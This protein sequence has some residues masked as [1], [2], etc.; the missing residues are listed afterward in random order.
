MSATGTMA[1]PHAGDASGPANALR[2][3]A[4]SAAMR[5]VA[6]D[7]RRE[8]DPRKFTA[9]A[10]A[11]MR[12]LCRLRFEQFGAAGRAARLTPIQPA[13]M[14]RAYETGELTR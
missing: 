9:P 11:A 13:A 10:L 14:A 6:I 5:R 4:M 1:G 7:D 12:D 2:A 8:F 3:L